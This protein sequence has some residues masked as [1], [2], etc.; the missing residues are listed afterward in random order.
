MPNPK[1]LQ[2]LVEPI[3]ISSPQEFGKV[4]ERIQAELGDGYKVKVHSGYGDYR[5]IS[6]SDGEFTGE[7]S[8]ILD[9]RLGAY[10]P[11]AE[12][13]I[14][15]RGRG[16][17]DVTS[18]A[19]VGAQIG[20][21]ST[22][23]TWELKG[24]TK[25]FA[26]TVRATFYQTK[27]ERQN[28][29]Q[30]RPRELNEIF[31]AISTSSDKDK[32]AHTRNKFGLA[33]SSSV[34]Y[35][36]PG[37]GE[38]L[39]MADKLNVGFT[40]NNYQQ[41]IE[42]ID[43]LIKSGMLGTR[44]L[45]GKIIQLQS[46]GAWRAKK[47]RAGVYSYERVASTEVVTKASGAVVYEPMLPRGV[48]GDPASITK[49]I[50]MATS[51]NRSR[52]VTVY[53]IKRDA[54]GKATIIDPDTYQNIDPSTF[55]DYMMS[56]AYNPYVRSGLIHPREKTETNVRMAWSLLTNTPTHEGASIMNQRLLKWMDSFGFVN[57]DVRELPFTKPSELDLG[58]GDNIRDIL[59]MA[60]D[61]EG[62]TIPAGTRRPKILGV[63][64]SSDGRKMKIR[65]RSKEYKQELLGA[66]IVIP[67]FMSPNGDKFFLLGEDP[68][69]IPTNKLAEQLQEKLAKYGVTVEVSGNKNSV[70][71]EYRF[72]GRVHASF[73]GGPSMVKSGYAAL[74]GPTPTI[75]IDGKS[76]NLG[77]ITKDSKQYVQAM[78][79]SWG[80]QPLENKF[81]M[82]QK[83]NGQLADWFKE[84]YDD[85]LKPVDLEE[86]GRQY[87]RFGGS[88]SHYYYLFSKMLSSFLNPASEKENKENLHRYGIYAI[89]GDTIV[90]TG[91]ISE[92]SLKLQ[93]DAARMQGVTLSEI[94]INAT[95]VDGVKGMY[96]YSFTV[97]ENRGVLMPTPLGTSI[98]MP[99]KAREINSDIVAA[100][101][102][103]YP[104][105]AKA[106]GLGIGDER[107]AGS[108]RRGW[109]GFAKAY[110]YNTS[111]MRGNVYVPKEAKTISRELAQEILD[112][113]IFDKDMTEKEVMSLLRDKI[114]NQMLFFDTTNRFLPSVEDVMSIDT[115]NEGVN[116]GES[117]SKY[118]TQYINSIKGLLRAEVL[119]H[120]DPIYMESQGKFIGG[121]TSRVGEILTTGKNV[122]RHLTGKETKGA[123]SGHYL[124][125]NAL[126]NDEMYLPDSEVIRLGQKLGLKTKEEFKQLFDYIE[127]GDTAS[128][129][130]RYPTVDVR[131][132]ISKVKIVGRKEMARRLNVDP[133]GLPEINAGIMIV[134]PGVVEKH[135][136]D[137]D[138]DPG[139]FKVGFRPYYVTQKEMD[140]DGNIRK[141]RK[142]LGFKNQLS[143]DKAY[144]AENPN[145]LAD[146]A[147]VIGPEL[148]SEYSTAAKAIREYI[149]DDPFKTAK[150][151]GTVTM[152]QFMEGASLYERIMQRRGTSHVSLSLM[153]AGFAAVGVPKDIIDQ[154]HGAASL[155][156]ETLESSLEAG[157]ASPLEIF[158]KSVT[159]TVADGSARSNIDKYNQKYLEM[160]LALGE[161]EEGMPHFDPIFSSTEA[162]RSQSLNNYIRTIAR[163]FSTMRS[164]SNEA[165][166]AG[167]ADPT[168][169]NKNYAAI[170]N[171]LKEEERRYKR[172]LFDKQY[173]TDA[174]IDAMIL[175][176]EERK[177]FLEQRYAA[178]FGNFTGQFNAIES[179]FASEK[180]AFSLMGLTLGARR[181]EEK[182]LTE[183]SERADTLLGLINSENG[184]VIPYGDKNY[185]I[186]EF[187]DLPEVD[188]LLSLFNIATGR[189]SRVNEGRVPD[190]QQ[191]IDVA[192]TLSDEARKTQM[193]KNILALEDLANIRDAA[194]KSVTG[195]G[196]FSIESAMSMIL[197]GSDVTRA[198]EFASFAAGK[199]HR[200]NAIM[201]AG[202]MIRGILGSD[203]KTGEA[204]IDVD[205][206]T[207]R[208]YEEGNAF[209]L[210]MVYS[211]ILGDYTL[212][213]RG[214][215]TKT[216]AADFKTEKYGRREATG[217]PDFIKITDGPDG[218]ILEIMEAKLTKSS[219]LQGNIQN[220][221]YVELLKRMH[222]Q[223]PEGLKSVL[224]SWK[225][226]TDKYYAD[227]VGIENPMGDDFVDKAIEAISKGRIKARI[228]YKDKRNHLLPQA[229]VEVGYSA[230][231][232][233]MGHLE[234]EQVISGVQNEW[235]VAVSHAARLQAQQIPEGLSEL[236][237]LAQ[238]GRIVLGDG[239]HLEMPKL[240]NGREIENVA[241]LF[242]EA[243]QLTLV[244]LRQNTGE[245]T[246]SGIPDDIRNQAKEQA[247][248]IRAHLRNP[249]EESPTIPG[250]PESENPVTNGG[251]P[252]A[253]MNSQEAFAASKEGAYIYVPENHFGFV[254][255]QSQLFEW[256]D[257][258]RGNGPGGG[259]RMNSFSAGTK[260]DAAARNIGR[261]GLMA[262]KYMQQNQGNVLD[263]L[264]KVQQ[265]ITPDAS[266][267]AN[268]ADAVAFMN[269][270]PFAHPEEFA[271]EMRQNRATFSQYGQAISAVEAMMREFGSEELLQS[272]MALM[273]P[274]EQNDIRSMMVGMG[275]KNPDGTPASGVETPLTTAMSAAGAMQM[276]AKFGEQQRTTGGVRAD[277][278]DMTDEARTKVIAALTND[279]EK[280]DAALQPF[281][282]GLEDSSKALNL[283][284]KSGREAAEN[285]IK[286]GKSNTAAAAMINQEIKS[287]ES[288]MKPE[289]VTTDERT[290]KT[291]RTSIQADGTPVT[292]E[293]TGI[294]QAEYLQQQQKLGSL[295]QA[296]SK[297]LSTPEE[298]RLG[299]IGNALRGIFGGFGL[300]YMSRVL[301]MGK[302]AIFQGSQE[303]EQY[304]QSIDKTASAFYGASNIQ[305]DSAFTRRQNALIR[306]GGFS[307]NALM[308]F[309]TSMIG[310]KTGDFINAGKM[311]AGV[312][313]AGS[314]I[315][316]E[317]AQAG[318]ISS[319]AAG[320]ALLPLGLVAGA[321]GVGTLAYQQYQYRENPDSARMSAYRDM[322]E[323]RNKHNEELAF[324][325]TLQIR[326]LSEDMIAY[327]Q[328]LEEG[329]VPVK[330]KPWSMATAGEA[331]WTNVQNKEEFNYAF[332]SG[333][334]KG[335]LTQ[336]QV[337]DITD[338][339]LAIDQKAGPI[340]DKFAGLSG[341][342][343]Y[344]G[345]TLGSRRGVD[346]SVRLAQMVQAGAP[347]QDSLLNAL[348]V[349]GQKYSLDSMQYLSSFISDDQFLEM[350]RAE[351][352]SAMAS[353]SP[354]VLRRTG[355]MSSKDAFLNAVDFRDFVRSDSYQLY[356]YQNNIGS[357]HDLTGYAPGMNYY[358]PEQVSAMSN[359][360][361]QSVFRQMAYTN[362]L[363][364]TYMSYLSQGYSQQYA[365]ESN[366]TQ[367]KY[368]GVFGDLG[369]NAFDTFRSVKGKLIDMGMTEKEAT[370]IANTV[371]VSQAQGNIQPMNMLGLY[372]SGSPQAIGWAAQDASK[373]H[374][375]NVN[376]IFA[377]TSIPQITTA[378]MRSRFAA[379]GLPSVNGVTVPFDVSPLFG[380]TNKAPLTSSFSVSDLAKAVAG[381]YITSEAAKSLGYA[382]AGGPGFQGT[383]DQ[384]A[385]FGIEGVQAK[386]REIRLQASRASAGAQFAQIDLQRRYW[387]GGGSMG[388]GLWA[389]QDD[390]RALQHEQQMYGFQT[391]R[392][393]LQMGYQQSLQSE[394]LNLAGT[395]MQRGF[396]QGDWDFQD[397]TRNLQW[398]WKKSDFAEEVRFM[399]GRQRRIAE[400][401][402]T[403]ENIMHDLEGEQIDK[404]RQQQKQLW[405]LEDQ[406]FALD[407]KFR[408]E[409]RAFSEEQIRRQ[410]EYYLKGKELDDEQLELTRKYQ[411]EGLAL[412]AGALAVQQQYSEQ[413]AEEEG[414]LAGIQ[415]Y[416]NSMISAWER[417]ISTLGTA[418]ILK[419]FFKLIGENWNFGNGGANY[420]GGTGGK[421]ANGGHVIA[422]KDYLIG[423]RGPEIFTPITSGRIE[424]LG[425]GNP[426][427]STEMFSSSGSVGRGG[428]GATTIVINLGNQKL[429]EYVI[430]A[431][432]ENLEIM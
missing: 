170:F 419:L 284:S 285:L 128:I 75:D 171:R 15:I 60:A 167:L 180:G 327:T 222:A 70:Q 34:I 396:T 28:E 11:A 401:Q 287:I 95:P 64:T 182:A 263:L 92:D 201:R 300:F 146:L 160:R 23:G 261:K 366:A 52:P 226:G 25:I 185:T 257:A 108:E 205:E 313:L 348:K 179:G 152:E 361:K 220:S 373:A 94:G 121:N 270:V 357:V 155:Y 224:E 153:R 82:L 231:K 49:T 267:I 209:E 158:Q 429:G 279:I 245:V 142:L 330:E 129:M 192:S 154:M 101:R 336:E 40:S 375:E 212:V 391:Q 106:A 262:Y 432:K 31:T 314:F 6:I 186:K 67:P 223:N 79:D 80:I 272:R 319:L 309:E 112:S 278:M 169:F 99:G 400:R 230:P 421:R 150:D 228:I 229:P 410:E 62:L 125:S 104:D 39:S 74:D 73:K 132:G 403:R 65:A 218:P 184:R 197:H 370:D 71:F 347:I 405:A 268:W 365:L 266:P 289:E 428:G 397:Q 165:L 143:S 420:E 298:S 5:R 402:N 29:F 260:S 194:K 20:K 321:V 147:Q 1:D 135:I 189:A 364:G 116:Y 358:T 191:L 353:I 349:S 246:G 190:V 430:R 318:I 149:H 359:Q 377:G 264:K 8:L 351:G 126:G 393:Q 159:F 360:E 130:W 417:M 395:Y 188:A 144:Q 265:K 238:K 3:R 162:A 424:P 58:D 306:A 387:L 221:F 76:I 225:T 43:N 379:G 96:D 202:K 346:E 282:A 409:N 406:R 394:A 85:P 124:V 251:S 322:A 416:Q 367:A 227:Y 294:E 136:G 345:V 127:T 276:A 215:G 17:V 240:K 320:S 200:S 341:G 384:H 38:Q 233:D 297:L 340:Y 24:P 44:D 111:A 4:I 87:E 148:T 239:K 422:G 27:T 291:Y 13:I 78:A 333:K 138:D 54:T 388:R 88:K 193:G 115:Y 113:G 68:S 123:L 338:Y 258:M 280:I 100:I 252:A 213:P 207:K 102:E 281:Q 312:G 310:T 119:G 325:E 273:T 9:I 66:K 174:E 334:F 77:T 275:I 337:R 295:K 423:E 407:R 383:Y 7:K 247:A 89:K 204:D 362:T 283:H 354:G 255:N 236:A 173:A 216:V 122:F 339:A 299:N 304:Q 16:S 109:R 296:Q 156:Q 380:V 315:L 164:I 274:E 56:D 352:L 378:D 176:N 57:R 408:E 51:V 84:N 398:N 301:G 426:W 2:K 332:V 259:G 316:S 404:K 199:Y 97:K 117:V 363:Q 344:A 311:G 168:D 292:R 386:M 248:R 10:T 21:S 235:D 114:G 47:I 217:L 203:F 305:R 141:V 145:P 12:P 198:S 343:I 90:R 208:L 308:D 26:D 177:G 385:Y 53:P 105:Y 342:A 381:G 110:M 72:M 249:T 32:Y 187:L 356:S 91:R 183:D 382:T 328:N 307:G 35:S 172:G 271:N 286:A 392:Q 157:Q 140:K 219:A 93:Q 46:M 45:D 211:G 290:G 372:M 254:L 376:S 250:V 137:E 427:A 335:N 237:M 412:Q 232:F 166:A 36:I 131:H 41:E 133:S 118:S 178:L 103:R 317:A 241:N 288:K 151:F 55:G 83:V 431:V 14:M 48:K 234:E 33:P 42:Q 210:A 139:G 425:Q 399:T 323:T 253:T 389:I 22:N 214:Y 244:P 355:G 107:D 195:V 98:E 371:G 120:A 19:G 369:V 37:Q 63:A 303:Y 277:L 69:A 181:A 242:K 196:G 411:L 86:L 302:E 18:E 30:R 329:L 324:D 293:M 61:L 81:R 50:K 161:N 256:A 134:G 59:A 415:E 331:E 414:K 390:Q 374:Y 175:T 413:L 206:N 350:A 326:R 269:D 418:E 243:Y 368:R 163:G